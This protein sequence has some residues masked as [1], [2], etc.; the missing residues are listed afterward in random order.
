[1]RKGEQMKLTF[2]KVAAVM[3]L[4]TMIG[5]TLA[6]PAGAAGTA[7]VTPNPIPV[8]SGQT[9]A[10]LTVDYNFGA[11]NTAVFL[12]LC[13]K[14]SSDPTFDPTI[15]CDRGVANAANGS[16]SGAG[17]QQLEIP[18]GDSA[19]SIIFG[20]T[21]DKWGCYPDGFTPSAGFL[22]ASKC[23]I[24]VTQGNVANSTDAVDV[25]LVYAV[26]GQEIP[27][28]P[29]VILPVLLGAIGVGGWF[30]VN[31]RRQAVA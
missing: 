31:R 5:L 19:G 29:F 1:M 23:Y 11:S 18:I 22:K 13:K 26:G 20:D 27:E 3:G 7:S 4:M 6:A 21:V 8:T 15:D 9:T 16:A 28:A 25:E 12:D 2:K 17:S 10:T 14:L 30:Y 24:R